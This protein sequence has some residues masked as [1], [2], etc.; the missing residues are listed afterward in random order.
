MSSLFD[1]DQRRKTIFYPKTDV[2]PGDFYPALRVTRDRD[3]ERLM[4]VV[5]DI[6]KHRW[7]QPPVLVTPITSGGTYQLLFIVEIDPSRRS[8]Q[9]L[10]P[11]GE[12]GF[13]SARGE[14]SRQARLEPFERFVIRLNRLPQ[15]ISWEFYIDHWAYRQLAALGLP[16]P[17]VVAVDVSRD[18]CPTD[19]QIMTYV[20]AKPLN[21]FEDP[22]TQYMDPALLQAVG[23]YVA[24]V[25][26]VPLNGFG[27][28]SIA[29]CAR[30][31]LVEE[32]ERSIPHGIHASWRD[33]IF[34]RLEEHLEVCQR[35]GALIATEVNQIQ[36][37]FEQHREIFDFG[38]PVWLHGDLGN[39]NMLSRDG[40][41]LTALIDWED[42]M[43][44]DPIFDIAFWGTFF[45]DHML[46]D[47][48]E[49]YQQVKPLPHDFYQRY[50]L[51]YLRI[52][53][54]KTVHRIRFGYTDR[55]GRPPASQR[56][57]KALSKMQT[58]GV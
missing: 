46:H 25:H 24:R 54:S 19:Y 40:V 28:L 5:H 18:H 31:E 4:P 43:S 45:R 51:Y 49:G 2:V 6:C 34:L 23:R 35:S 27:P 58:L 21:I 16:G 22:E 30:P 20:D 48:L 36:K 41:T 29:S 33:Y 37:L 17:E 12:R 50:W 14:E 13:A 44:G 1:C 32:F 53:L 57:Q 7:S 38:Q 39:H 3:I 52:A 15:H 26:T 11:Q 42:S 8:P 9:G 10:A 55:P 56:I 47:F